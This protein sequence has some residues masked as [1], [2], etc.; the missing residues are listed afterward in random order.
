MK[1][2]RSIGAWL[3]DR[4]GISDT[5]MPLARHLVP[6][7]A[8]WSYVFGS[9]AMFCLILQVVTGLALTLLYQP[10]SSEAYQSLQFITHQAVFGRTLRAIH[11]FGASGMVLL[12]GVHMMRVYITASYKFPR[13]MSWISGVF[14]LFLT[15]AMGFTGQLL[16][17]DSNGVWSAVVAAEQVGRIPVI[18]T[19]VARLLLG[20]DTIG[21]QSLS[22]FYSYHT[23]LFPGLLLGLV[24]FHLYLVI[25]NGVSEPPVAGRPVDPKTY[26]QWYQAM[27]KKVGVPFWPNAA[28]RDTLFGAVVI[29]SIFGLALL[30]GP[31]ELTTP[32]SPATI[33]T[34]PAPDWYLLPVFALFALMPAKI[35][36][37][38]IFIGPI[39]TVIGLLA[40]PFVSNAGERS[41]LRRPWA[42]FGSL[43]VVV[44]VGALLLLGEQAPWSP[45]F[46]AQPLTA[47]L[48]HSSDPQ[49]VAG[50]A[51]FYNK[52]CLYCHLIDGHGGRRGP[53]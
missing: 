29:L 51:L 18:G 3:D 13:E 1:I 28:W 6:P 34:N 43:C 44:F 22:R 12:V 5:I 45:K 42:V 47:G 40:L 49:V 11:Y 46:T 24:G 23:L 36:S 31:P 10:T 26:R 4:L 14:L 39:L 17:W 37:Y 52:G 27:L 25:R 33:N 2:L 35:E 30:Y 38:V 53:S 48:V 9:A 32:P 21:G 20:G 41:P 15:L 7:G 50:S 19:Y 8:K 16:R